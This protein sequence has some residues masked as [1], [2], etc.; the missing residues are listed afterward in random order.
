MKYLNIALAALATL[1]GYQIAEASRL[2]EYYD[3]LTP[4]QAHPTAAEAATYPEWS[5]AMHDW[6]DNYQ[7]DPYTVT[8]QD[9]YKLTMFKITKR[10]VSYDHPHRESVLYQHGYGNDA[11]T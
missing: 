6:I 3:H 7:W 1:S 9:G 10:G 5:I 2:T 11:M 8:T 4:G